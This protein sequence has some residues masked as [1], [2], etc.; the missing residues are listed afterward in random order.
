MRPATPRRAAGRR[1]GPRSD[2]DAAYRCVGVGMEGRRTRG[3]RAG[4]PVREGVA[5]GDVPRTDLS[6]F[7]SQGP[8][9]HGTGTNAH[10]HGRR[11]QTAHGCNKDVRVCG[12]TARAVFV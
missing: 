10:R 1:T 9:A 11:A 5:G 4:E 12:H 6:I 3:G 2:C 7:A 8:A